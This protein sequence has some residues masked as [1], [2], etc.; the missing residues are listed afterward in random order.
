MGKSIS[1][2]DTID[3]YEIYKGIRKVWEINPKTKV[4]HNG[5]K[6][7]RKKIKKDFKKQ[8]KEDGY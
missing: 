2:K 4:V 6:K 3:C 5:K 8:L 7:S 1:K